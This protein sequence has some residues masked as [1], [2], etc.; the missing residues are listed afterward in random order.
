MAEINRIAARAPAT[1][2]NVPVVDAPVV[3]DHPD[4]RAKALLNNPITDLKCSINS[5]FWNWG[6]GEEPKE[7]YSAIVKRWANTDKTKVYIL[8]ED[9]NQCKSQDIDFVDE[10]TTFL[11]QDYLHFT[12]DGYTDGKPAPIAPTSVANP[13]LLASS[14]LRDP[15]VLIARADTIMAGSTAYFDHTIMVGR[16]AQVERMQHSQIFNPLHA[17]PHPLHAM[18]LHAMAL[19]A[20]P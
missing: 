7:R 15:N 3:V 2:L 12:I 20:M 4:P 10:G 1:S 19:H 11:M 14:N 16:A 9:Q 13:F 5:A 18:A 17:N 6:R 8:W